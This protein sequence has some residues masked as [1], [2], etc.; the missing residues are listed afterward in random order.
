MGEIS[1]QNLTQELPKL[2]DRRAIP[3]KSLWG[4][5]KHTILAHKLPNPRM[6]PCNDPRNIARPQKGELSFRVS[7]KDK[8][9]RQTNF[10]IGK[11]LISLDE[12]IKEIAGF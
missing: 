11:D 4:D 2:L 1:L 10:A 5:S 9:S 7:E 12:L 3:R 8:V 6:T